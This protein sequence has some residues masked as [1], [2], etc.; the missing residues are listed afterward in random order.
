M[1]L[2]MSLMAHNAP[3]VLCLAQSRI[4]DYT[5]GWSCMAATFKREMPRDQGPWT[6][7]IQFRNGAER[8]TGT[9]TGH[10]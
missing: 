10:F 4:A 8:N 5:S 7:A 6:S 1:P 9:A 2:K 3:L